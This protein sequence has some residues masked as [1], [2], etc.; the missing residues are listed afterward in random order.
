MWVL[1]NRKHGTSL[2]CKDFLINIYNLKH[3]YKI[4]T[5]SII[6]FLRV[7]GELFVFFFFFS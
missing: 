2:S 3:L 5:K 7:K 1:A 6:D 4:D